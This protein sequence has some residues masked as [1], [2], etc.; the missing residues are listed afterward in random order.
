MN[1]ISSDSFVVRIHLHSNFCHNVSPCRVGFKCVTNSLTKFVLAKFAL[2][3]LQ[4]SV[5]VHRVTN[6]V[7]SQ[8]H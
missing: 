7:F 6:C 8:F 5:I 1:T 3:E 4:G 2:G